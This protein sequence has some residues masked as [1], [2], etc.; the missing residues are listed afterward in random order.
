MD[1]LTPLGFD[2]LTFRYGFSTPVFVSFDYDFDAGATLL[3]GPNGAGKSTMLALAASVMTPQGG[4][5][6]FNGEDVSR[7]QP[8]RRLRQVVGWLPQFTYPYPGMRVKEQVAYAGWLKGMTR[9][10]IRERVD[11]VIERVD[12][13]ALSDRYVSELSGGE[14]RRVGLAQALVHEPSIILLDEPTAGL[15]PVEIAHFGAILG[16]LSGYSALVL[17]THRIADYFEHFDFVTV[18]S[19]GRI[20]YRGTAQEFVKGHAGYTEAYIN[21]LRGASA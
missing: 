1:S 7:R 13:S 4:V 11:R 3:L 19:T 8:R 6:R 14:L 5:V 17:S 10:D 18:I 16:Q 2:G 12:L 20:C 15:D 9:S 21:A